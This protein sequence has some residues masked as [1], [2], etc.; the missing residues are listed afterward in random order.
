MDTRWLREDRK[1][2]KAEQA[3]A[4]EESKKALKNSTLLVR[5]LTY[6]LEEE[7]EKTYAT[8]DSY[9]GADWER[10]IQRMF[11]RRQTL[12]EILKLLP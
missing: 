9:E 5:R 8:E 4:I 10:T 6:I 3:K 11:A 1:L 2:P 7:V 12:K